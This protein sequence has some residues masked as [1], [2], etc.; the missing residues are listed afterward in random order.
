MNKF[1]LKRIVI[2]EVTGISKELWNDLCDYLR[3][4]DGE[5]YNAL[6][7]NPKRLQSGSKSWLPYPYAPTGEMA[8]ELEA[9]KKFIGRRSVWLVR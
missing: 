1:E 4:G 8:E 9:L 2:Y 7:W 3:L 6:E 5:Y